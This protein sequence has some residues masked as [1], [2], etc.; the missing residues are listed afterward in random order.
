MYVCMYVI[1]Y[2][3]MYVCMSVCLSVCMC[4]R[5]LAYLKVTC[6]VFTKFSVMLPVAVARSFSD[7]LPLPDLWMTSSFRVMGPLGQN[8]RRR[9]LSSLASGG[10]SRRPR[11]THRRRTLLSRI[12]FVKFVMTAETRAV[13]ASQAEIWRG[14]VIYGYTALAR[15]FRGDV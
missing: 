2:V 8:Q 14:K 12:A 4:V 5:L 13:Y 10:N 1:M 3:C 7:L 11:Y 9:Y 15:Q 6:P